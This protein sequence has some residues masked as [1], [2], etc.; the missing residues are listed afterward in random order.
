VVQKGKY[1]L[2]ISARALA[3]YEKLFD[4][5][6]PL[7]KLDTLALPEGGSGAMENWVSIVSLLFDEYSTFRL[8]R[9][10]F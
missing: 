6:Y 7:P 5:E 4:I 8:R 9:A 2:D 10:L 3:V 1:C